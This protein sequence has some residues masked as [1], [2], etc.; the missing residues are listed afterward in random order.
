[1]K[2]IT[3][4]TVLFVIP[5]MVLL[6]GCKSKPNVAPSTETAQQPPVSQNVFLGNW[7]GTDK[8][9]ATYNLRFSPDLRWESYIEEGGASRPHYR[10]TY[11]PQGSQVRIRI[12]EEADLITMGWIPEKGNAPTNITG[13]FQGNVLKVGSILTDAE[14]R[15]R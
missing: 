1:M 12:T 2:T 9:G 4:I 14:L 5:A 10:G 11:E 7:V 6:L 8:S 15:R 3:K 13:R